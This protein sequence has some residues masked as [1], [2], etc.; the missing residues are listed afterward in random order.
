MHIRWIVAWQ[1]QSDLIFY[2]NMVM[3]VDTIQQAVES[4]IA[5]WALTDKEKAYDDEDR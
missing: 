2:K 4:H 3:D 1:T 5:A